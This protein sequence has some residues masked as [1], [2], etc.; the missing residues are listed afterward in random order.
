MYEMISGQYAAR[1]A[2]IPRVAPVQALDG[3]SHRHIAS[4]LAGLCPNACSRS[5][6]PKVFLQNSSKMAEPQGRSPAT[7]TGCG[8][9]AAIAA[10]RGLGPL[11]SG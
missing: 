9:S 5:E 10:P 2:Y 1:L 4:H 7:G 11:L 6:L 3:A 8:D